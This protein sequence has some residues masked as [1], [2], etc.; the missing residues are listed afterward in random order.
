MRWF[1]FDKESQSGSFEK[2]TISQTN[3]WRSKM[4]LISTQLVSIEV[5]G[6]LRFFSPTFSRRGCKKVLLNLGIRCMCGLWF[7]SG[8]CTS[9][10]R[11]EYGPSFS[12]Q[13]PGLY[14]QGRTYHDLVAYCQCCGRVHKTVKE[15]NEERYWVFVRKAVLRY[16]MRNRFS[17]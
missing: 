7:P 11:R 8:L 6:P 16:K 14:R 15:F 17:Q 9:L 5:T 12:D 10:E 13:Y 4:K 2:D 1:L 3:K